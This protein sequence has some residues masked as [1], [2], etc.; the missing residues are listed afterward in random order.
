MKNYS[1]VF[2]MW[3]RDLLELEDMNLIYSDNVTDV[4]SL[5]LGSLITKKKKK[6]KSSLKFPLCFNIMP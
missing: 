4:F 6:K 1:H 2:W 3:L 5:I